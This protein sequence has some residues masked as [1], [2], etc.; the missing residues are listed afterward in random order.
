M[1]HGETAMNDQKAFA[2]IK[3]NQLQLTSLL[4]LTLL[5]RWYSYR[6]YS[7]LGSAFNEGR[8]LQKKVVCF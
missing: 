1:V 8:H 4:K 3:L 2:T 5:Q 6:Y 7:L